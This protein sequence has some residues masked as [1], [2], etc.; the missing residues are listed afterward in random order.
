MSSMVVKHVLQPH[1]LTHTPYLAG[2]GLGW[3]VGVVKLGWLAWVGL[4]V[5]VSWVW[6]GWLALGWF[7]VLV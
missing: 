5:E 1:I 3:L 6:L 2:Q 4:V 7:V